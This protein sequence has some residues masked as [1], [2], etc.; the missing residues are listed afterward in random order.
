MFFKHPI[1]VRNPL[2]NPV[3][4]R[5]EIELPQF[6]GQLG[7]ELRV[8]SRGGQKFE[9]A[10]RSRRKVK[11]FMKPG[12]LFSPQ[13][14]REAIANGD[15]EINIRTYLNDELSGGMTYPLSFDAKWTR[16]VPEPEPEVP[17]AEFASEEAT[18]P[19]KAAPRRASTMDEIIRA[20]REAPEALTGRSHAGG[21]IRTGRIEF[22]LD[23]ES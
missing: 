20:L 8:A 15:H 2:Q 5:I 14:V 23:D 17:S 21:R 18:T 3:S 13:Q 11:L 19:A 1:W 6:L 9:L 4:C 22:D 12:K 7:W 16:A 10:P